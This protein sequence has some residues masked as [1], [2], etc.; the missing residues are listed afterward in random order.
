MLA[1]VGAPV[2]SG[3]G[4]VRSRHAVHL[5]CGEGMENRLSLPV[6]FL[7]APPSKQN[8]EF[9]TAIINSLFTTIS[10]VTILQFLM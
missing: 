9:T 2:R 6:C 1:E 8:Y 10:Y 7:G 5:R 3:Y 4:V